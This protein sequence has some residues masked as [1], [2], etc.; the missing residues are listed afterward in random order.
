M[1]PV[2]LLWGVFVAV[3]IC[4]SS[5]DLVFITHRPSGGGVKSALMWTSLWITVALGFGALIWFVHPKGPDVAL[6]FVTGYLTEYSLSVDNLFVFILIFSQMG[7]RDSA[8]PKLIKAGIMLSIVMRIIFI[9]FGVTLVQRFHWMIPIFGVI[10][11][12]TAWKMLTAKQRKPIGRSIIPDPRHG[13]HRHS[14]PAF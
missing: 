4:V 1:N 2:D 6:L 7:V 12:W 13:K 14:S 11:I 8:Q 10:L 3:V 9:L 5:L